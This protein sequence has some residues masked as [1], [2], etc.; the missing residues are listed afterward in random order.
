MRDPRYG[1]IHLDANALEPPDP[2]DKDLV[3]EFLKLREN[4]VISVVNP[5]GVQRELDDPRTPSSTRTHTEGIYTLQTNQ[6]PQEESVLSRLQDLM[7]GGAAPGRHAA[8]AEH[9]FEASKYGGI[10]FVTHDGRIIRKKSEIAII[11]GPL[12]AIVTLRQFIDI[13]RQYYLA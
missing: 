3:P 6:I 1:N 10:Y 2:A 13:C 5:H 11:L 9:V 4:D 12:P 7:R 8:D